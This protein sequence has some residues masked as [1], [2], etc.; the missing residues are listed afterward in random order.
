MV[1]GSC[2]SS[3]SWPR[4]VAPEG[5]PGS[6]EPRPAS[7]IV[8]GLWPEAITSVIRPTP[9]ST[10]DAERVVPRDA[11][12]LSLRYGNRAGVLEEQQR[13]CV[14]AHQ[15]AA[16]L[17]RHRDG[18]HILLVNDRDHAIRRQRP[19]ETQ[20]LAGRLCRVPLAPRLRLNAPAK[21]DPGPPLRKPGPDP[22]DEFSG[23]DQLNGPLTVPTEAPV[24][25][26]KG[27]L[28]SGA[29]AIHQRAVGEEAC[30]QWIG[31]HAR[32]GVE[33]SVAPLPQPQPVRPHLGGQ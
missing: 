3:L 23:V 30:V 21:L 25:S 10:L 17:V 13:A 28:P 29:A 32:V 6:P 9:T 11:S 19:R 1:N 27:H 26:Y 18:G 2:E 31:D 12:H 33:V 5:P 16:E 24:S 20:R 8:V 15:R 14:G 7:S 22:A 4:I